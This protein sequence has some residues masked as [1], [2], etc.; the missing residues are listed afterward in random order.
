MSKTIPYATIES[1]L[2]LYM[3]WKSKI[4]LLQSQLDHIPSLAQHMDLVAIYG[5]G[6]HSESVVKEAIR[7]VQI[8]DELPILKM[9]VQLLSIAL[10]ALTKEESNFVEMKYFDRESNNL[11]MDQMHLS[12][13]AFF[14]MRKA[15]LEKM[16]SLLGGSTSLLWLEIPNYE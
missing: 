10:S 11:V 6:G 3:S 16:Y 7:R 13:G 14:R 12:R 1:W 2:R 4:E 8:S 5:K 15:V 9:K